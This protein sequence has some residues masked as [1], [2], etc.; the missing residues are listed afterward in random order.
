MRIGINRRHVLRVG[1][2]GAVGALGTAAGRGTA[3]A[4][5]AA[6]RTLQFEVDTAVVTGVIFSRD[7]GV[8]T[9]GVPRQQGD[10]CNIAWRLHPIDQT[11]G[12]PIGDWHCIGPWVGSTK[13]KGAAGGAFLVTAQIELYGRGKLSG[14]VYCGPGWFDGSITGGTGE[15]RGASG[16]FRWGPLVPGISRMQ[17]DI[18]LPDPGAATTSKYTEPSVTV[19]GPAALDHSSHH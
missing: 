17:F 14:V 8:A 9:T 7:G 5:R 2:L 10:H 19:N 6:S 1:T 3:Q 12:E 4:T 11:D 16:S 18:L 13:E 15:F